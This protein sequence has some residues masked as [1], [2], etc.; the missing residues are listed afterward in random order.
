MEIIIELTTSQ[1]YCKDQVSSCIQSTWNTVWH[2][3]AT[4][5]LVLFTIV[6][7]T[8]FHSPLVMRIGLLYQI[9]Q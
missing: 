9:G 7:N 1:V 8:A 2:I 5:V 3:S 6:I 4:K